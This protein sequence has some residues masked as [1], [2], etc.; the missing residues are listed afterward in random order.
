MQVD[1]IKPTLKAPGIKLL[2]LKCDKPLSNFAFNFNLRRYTQVSADTSAV[3]KFIVMEGSFSHG[4]ASALDHSADSAGVSWSAFFTG[5]DKPADLNNNAGGRINLGARVVANGI[6]SSPRVELPSIF[7]IARSTSNYGARLMLPAY[8][9]DGG[10]ISLSIGTADD[11]G[12]IHSYGA[13]V[14]AGNAT[15]T[16]T[17]LASTYT[18]AAGYW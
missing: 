11:H 15:L 2:K 18:A 14:A 17:A 5:G 8:D 16:G 3:G 12:G 1:P 6:N 4:Y 9:P 7:P 13:A 10:G